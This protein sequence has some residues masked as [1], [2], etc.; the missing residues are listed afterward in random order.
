MNYALSPDKRSD[1]AQQ[2][3]KCGLCLP[4]CPTY[5]I[6][7]NE[8]E[9]PR[10][11]IALMASMAQNP[12]LYGSER[13]PS[14]DNCLACRRCESACPAHV[15][16]D[17]LLIG[18]RAAM[19]PVLPW[20]AK[21][22]L[23]LM[24][25]KPWLNRLLALYRFTFKALP[26]QLKILPKPGNR[27][28]SN[29]APRPATPGRSAVFTGCVAD[30]YERNTRLA[31]LK[32]LQAA[33]ESAE[34]PEPQ[35]CCGQAAL[36]AGDG[37]TAQRLA[38]RNH[39]AFAGY[40]RLLVLASGCFSALQPS[41]GIPVIDAAVYLQQRGDALRF[42]SAQG[43]HIALHTPCSASFHGQ[44]AAMLA[45]LRNIPDLHITELAD[46]GCCGAAGLHQIVQPERARLL[47]GPPIEAVHASGAALLLSQ[48][49]GC[50]LHLG[51]GL[52]IPVLHPIEFMAQFLHD[53]PTP[54]DPH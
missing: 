24:A 19:K 21:T 54:T 43:L 4:H 9:S 10:G 18:S 34:T 47:A 51:N 3:V 12:D 32:L 16:Y 31:L 13:L 40:E 8:A 45:L 25:H 20:R 49:I 1:L 2:C 30:V 50:R 6:T 28:A 22:A 7:Q 11:R 27:A 33:G 5:A 36:H 52:R 53:I 42:K 37:D 14:L 17:A 23:W 46:Q 26:Q 15:S 48:N 35:S 39:V 29:N 38:E 41:A 44:H